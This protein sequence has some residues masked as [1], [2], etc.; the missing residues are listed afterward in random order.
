M[1]PYWGAD[2]I[3]FFTIFF[4]RLFTLDYAHY[5]A[6]EVQ[7]GVLACVAISCSLIGP[8][9]VLKKMTMF[10]NALS[11]TILLGVVS[12]FLILK[13][14]ILFDFSNLLLG[15]FIASVLTAI[16]TEGL[17]KWFSLSAD[18]S[19]G[20]VFSF[21]F[22]LG[23]VFVTL[24]AKDVHLGIESVMGNAD[25]LSVTDL[26]LSGSLA[27]LNGAFILFFYKH[28]LITSFDES[29]AKVLKMNAGGFRFVLLFL[30]A[31]TCIGAFRAV[32]VL[33]VLGFLVGP[34]LTARLFSHRLKPLIFYSCSI[35]VTAS[36]FGVATARHI[37]SI[38]DIPLSTG[39]IV[40]CYIGIFY[41]M[42]L[43]IQKGI[44]LNRLRIKGLR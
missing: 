23:I 36:L 26:R 38:Y 14:A 9:L 20:L 29:Y 37:L 34:Y 10:A 35:G 24:F 16:L 18:A 32:G 4:S 39:G 42:G 33:L 15:A 12:A 22:A 8:F 27:L 19:V 21:L 41:F 31:T 43:A 28:F 44:F 13:G 6:D 2:F 25:A 30:C 11:H 7:V 40:V 5:C 1:T 17:V 3:D